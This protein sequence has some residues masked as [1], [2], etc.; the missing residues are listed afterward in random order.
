MSTLNKKRVV[1][2]GATGTIGKALSKRLIESGYELVIF[3]RNPESA[4]ERVPGAAE[5]VAWK[6]EEKGS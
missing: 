3:S 5:Y 1:V 6:A 2:V 4:R